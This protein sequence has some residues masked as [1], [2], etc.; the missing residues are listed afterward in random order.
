MKTSRFVVRIGA[1]GANIM[2][3]LEWNGMIYIN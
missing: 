3:R 2:V 1:Y